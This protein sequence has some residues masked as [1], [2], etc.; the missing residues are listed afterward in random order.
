[1]QVQDI[2]TQNV[3]TVA[4]NATVEQATQL[5]VNHH[6]SALPVLEENGTLLGIVS[7]GDLMRRVEGASDQ[8]KSWWL[9]L[10]ADKVDSAA[11][12]IALKGRFVRD[13]MTSKVVTVTPE[14]AVGEVARLLAE[15]HIKR[16]PVVKNDRLVGIVSRA[17]LLHAL[18][19]IPQQKVNE[20]AN[21]LEKRE[22][23]L[24][25]LAQVPELNINHLNV[26]VEGGQVDVWG[27]ASSKEEERAIKVALENVSGLGN[28]SYNLG[29]LP[30]YAWGI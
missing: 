10:F 3:I 23:I 5:M 12:F 4:P 17:N 24:K 26:V 20:Q 25:T 16:A 2:M 14:M 8:K 7:E 11:D 15:K 13:V 30:G 6:I 22:I 27:V 28:V 9:Y 21:D 19:A 18:A 29:R 1:M